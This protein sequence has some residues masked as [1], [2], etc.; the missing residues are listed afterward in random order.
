M[1]LANKITLLRVGLT[2]FFALFGFLYAWSLKTEEPR[3]EMRWATLSVF[4]LA[5]ATD[6]LDGLIARRFR[7]QS[8]LGATLDPLADKLLVFTACILLSLE[9][10][11]DRFPIWFPA[12]VIGRDLILALGFLGLHYLSIAPAVQPS[13]LGKTTTV[14]QLLAIGWILFGLPGPSVYLAAPAA[15]A[16]LLSGVDYVIKGFRQIRWTSGSFSG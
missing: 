13:W 9:W 15:L 10:W 3:P 2:P 7:Q 5:A 6:A 12:V 4:V 14:L 8:K 11:P 1:T 16:T